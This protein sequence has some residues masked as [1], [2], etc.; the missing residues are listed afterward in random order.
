MRGL[1]GV[2]DPMIYGP[3]LKAALSDT[4]DTFNTLA[5]D[6]DLSEDDRDLVESIHVLV[7][8]LLL[9]DEVRGTTDVRV[10]E[11]I[12]NSQGK[13]QRLE[14]NGEEATEDP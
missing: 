12:R 2:D 11:I 8:Y 14:V 4:F 3:K 10:I 6:K 7:S 5:D 13:V 9:L 1:L